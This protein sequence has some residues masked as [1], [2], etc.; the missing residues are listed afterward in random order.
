M[1]YATIEGIKELT[2]LDKFREQIG[3]EIINSYQGVKDAFEAQETLIFANGE[4]VIVPIEKKEEIDD[5]FEDAKQKINACK[6]EADCV[7]LYPKVKPLFIGYPILKDLITAKRETLKPKKEE[8]PVAPPAEEKPKKPEPA[9]KP[10]KPKAEKPKAE[11][12]K[13]AV[14]DEVLAKCNEC[15]EKVSK[16]V[17]SDEIR[18]VIKDYEDIMK[19]RENKNCRELR[20]FINDTGNELDKKNS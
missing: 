9:L 3:E 20:S 4:P 13:T 14:E 5:I 16:C 10:E 19:N 18:L 1:I 8:A 12:I 11:E 15:R 2:E 6:I 17:N 7:A